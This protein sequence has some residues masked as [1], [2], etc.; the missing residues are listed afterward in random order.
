M[1]KKRDCDAK[2]LE[3]V[4]KLIEP[5]ADPDELLSSVSTLSSVTGI[6]KMSFN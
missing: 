3:V 1:Q 4:E 2:A 6:P 5:V